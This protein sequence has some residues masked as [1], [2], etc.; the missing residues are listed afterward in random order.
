MVSGRGFEPNV[1]VD[2][3]FGTKDEALVVTD[4]KGEFKDAKAHVPGSA[5]PGQHWV[6]ALERNNDKGAQEPFLV[7]TDWS[8]FHFDSDGT[9]L[10]AYENV[11]NENTVGSLRLHWN[12][13]SGRRFFGSPAVEHGVVYVP[14]WPDPGHETSN[15]YALR[16]DDG[17]L[18]WS[19]TAGGFSD[20]PAIAK[21]IVYVGGGTDLYA[22]N[23]K[24]GNLIW[25]FHTGSEIGSSPTVSNGAVYVGSG[26]F[27]LY[28]LD[29]R[30]GRKLWG[31]ATGSYVESSPTVANGTVFV[32]S[33]DGN[34]YAFNA[35]TGAL[36]W[37]YATRGI[38]SSSPTEANGVV[39]VGSYDGNV[40]AL[41]ADTGNLQWNYTTGGIVYSSPA[42]ADGVV[43]VGSGDHKVYA[44]DA[45]TGAKLWIYTARDQVNSSPA[46]ANGVIFVG[47][48][49]G[50][51]YALSART[52]AE[53][54]G[55]PLVVGGLEERRSGSF[56]AASC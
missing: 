55:V 24:N 37:S 43:Y 5:Y 16:V 29:A 53:I 32:G 21:G 41:N 7:Q 14:D 9:R 19:F 2:I 13:N 35:K 3:Y 15:L 20:C 31:H 47:S 4:S 46:V 44:L 27:N 22:L 28:A 54:D 23:S 48:D 45:S 36:L 33:F 10:N 8:E 17:S 6:T 30:S 52:G 39:Y 40:Y 51:V 38:V 50:H 1:G 25:S 49:D 56:Y 11:L 18:L 12:Y 42:V 34:V 26:D